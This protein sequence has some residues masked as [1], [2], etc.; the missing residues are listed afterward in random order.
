MALPW[1]SIDVISIPSDDESA[2]GVHSDVDADGSLFENIARESAP[3]ESL[4]PLSAL[5]ASTATARQNKVKRT[6]NSPEG[7]DGSEIAGDSDGLGCLVASQPNPAPETE[8]AS[9][10]SASGSSQRCSPPLS[11]SSQRTPTP[12]HEDELHHQRS[13]SPNLPAFATKSNHSH[14][15]QS[16][17]STP[18]LPSQFVHSNSAPEDEHEDGDSLSDSGLRIVAQSALAL[19]CTAQSS[20][21]SFDRSSSFGKDA[22]KYPV[23]DQFVPVGCSSTP[24]P[25]RQTQGMSRVTGEGGQSANQFNEPDQDEQRGLDRQRGCKTKHNLR[26]NP[27][28]KG[29]YGEG[30]DSE[31]NHLLASKRRRALIPAPRR[32]DARRGSEQLQG[33]KLHRAGKV[34]RGTGGNARST[35]TDNPAHAAIAIYEEWPLANAVLKCVQD[36][37]TAT[38]QLQFTWATE[39]KANGLPR[40]TNNQIPGPC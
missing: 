13:D 16:P 20:C 10:T 5:V 6:E 33:P 18:L 30:T 4:P 12:S 23:A 7:F 15:S 39:C 38:F 3:D 22:E 17:R 11:P 14:A 1:P 24:P 8:L 35:R 28:K 25:Q 37:G 31:D 34:K 2:F 32:R 36:N 27:P 9:P 40:S 21:A 26:P 29:F 19:P